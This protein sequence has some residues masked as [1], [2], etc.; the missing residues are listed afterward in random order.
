MK[1]ENQ[2]AFGEILRLSLPIML[3][4][5]SWTLTFTVGRIF[6]AKYDLCL[7]NAV[8]AVGT[9]GFIFENLLTSITVTSEIFS[10]QYNGKQEYKNVPIATWQ[11]IFFSVVLAP[12]YIILAFTLGEYIIPVEFYDDAK[13]Y[14][15]ISMSFLWLTGAKEAMAGFFLGIKKTRIIFYSSIVASIAS[16]SLTYFFLFGYGDYEPKLGLTA[17]GIAAAGKNII[18]F[19][20][21]FCF[22]ISKKM[23][24]K[25]NTR[26]IF[27]NKELFIKTIKIGFPNAIA[28]VGEVFGSYLVQFILVKLLRDFL[29]EYNIVLN[30]YILIMFVNFGIQKATTSAASNMIGDGDTKNLSKLIKESIKLL[31]VSYI[32]LLVLYS[33]FADKFINL[34]TTNPEEVRHVYILFF[35]MLLCAVI[36]G[37]GV[38]HSGVTVAGGDT[39][40]LMGVNLSVVWIFK[41][42]PTYAFI[43]LGYNQFYVPWTINVFTTIF[44]AA[45]MIYR[46]RSGKWL[47]LKLS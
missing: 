6:I 5:F 35:V 37:V 47:K 46:Y 16:L 2:I 9:L 1:K 28:V 12:I 3:T 24:E 27:F 15:R 23:H 42:V 21:V 4:M 36:D 38:I 8:F 33:A 40:Y 22:F 30:A 34:Y 32:I 11:M 26:A 13:N 29:T 43:K 25:Y 19:I 7:I 18:D 10:G 39:K 45:F 44:Y 41:V 17:V 14:F 20:I 31:I